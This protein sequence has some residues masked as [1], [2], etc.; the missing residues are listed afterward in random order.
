[1][2]SIPLEKASPA[3]SH[4][5][6]LPKG[7][8]DLRERRVQRVLLL[9]GLFLLVLVS[10][11]RLRHLASVLSMPRISGVRN[12]K[13][14]TRIES[15]SP[16]G[17]RRHK[18]I[19]R[20]LT[21]RWLLNAE[22][23]A[24]L[25]KLTGGQFHRLWATERKDLTRPGRGSGGWMEDSGNCPADLSTGRRSDHTGSGGSRTMTRGCVFLSSRR[26][27]SGCN[28]DAIGMQSGCNRDAIGMQSGC[29][30]DAIGMQS[31]CNRDAIV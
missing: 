30:R 29:N 4:D 21:T 1:M 27:Q 22:K 18:P 19:R 23:L 26:M 11:F 13:Y 9:I 15:E 12:P 16:F 7:A 20:D 31:G 14:R 5:R 8:L 6:A 17:C 24:G 3:H 2:A 28:R 25:L 10:H